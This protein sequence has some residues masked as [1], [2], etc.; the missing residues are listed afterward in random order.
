MDFSRLCRNHIFH[1]FL[2][3]S[4]C[5]ESVLLRK[6]RLHGK[7]RLDGVKH[8]ETRK[9]IDKKTSEGK[10]SISIANAVSFVRKWISLA[11]CVSFTSSNIIWQW[12]HQRPFTARLLQL[13]SALQGSYVDDVRLK[14]LIELCKL[15]AST[16]APSF[17]QMTRHFQ[18]FLSNG[19]LFSLPPDD[20]AQHVASSI[21]QA[22]RVITFRFRF[23]EFTARVWRAQR[24]VF[25]TCDFLFI[26][27]HFFQ[28][29]RADKE[30]S[31]IK[32]D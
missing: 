15:L 23:N 27:K 24:I 3:P 7:I 19:A 11:L 5:T 28:V 13:A 29:K 25:E 6:L 31:A 12:H 1:G 10:K 20:L 4:C 22:I 2:I 18:A 9:W 17:M 16:S 8:N 32:P 26:I 14:A 30:A 21:T